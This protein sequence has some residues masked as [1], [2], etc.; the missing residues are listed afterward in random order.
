MA[1]WPLFGLVVRTPRVEIR[2]PREDEFAALL[3]VIEGG[4]HDPSTM[5]FTTPFTDRP[6][7]ERGRE[8][9]Q[10][11]RRQRAEWS[12]EKWNFT[13]AVFVEGQVVGVQDMNADHFATLRSVHTGS[14]LGRPYQVQGLGKEMRQAI[15]HLAFEGLGAQEAHSGAF[16]DNTASLATSR[17]VGYVDNGETRAL[18]RGHADRIINVRMDRAMWAQ[19]RRND[20]EIIGLEECHDMFV[21]A[22]AADTTDP[23]S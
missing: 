4:I 8:S 13:G 21:S 17:S 10:W 6:A 5:P 19:R 2:L 20:I 16:H 14:W 23:I 9:A 1:F 12:A 22:P 11:W 18:R 3:A 7:P 15:L